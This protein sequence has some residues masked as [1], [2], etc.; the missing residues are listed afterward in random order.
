MVQALIDI[1]DRTNRILNIIKAKFDLQDKSQAI[2]AM[3]EQYEEALL[4]PSLR[5]A[6]IKR[7]QKIMKDKPIKIGTLA[8]F[9][10]R[11]RTQ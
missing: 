3:A 7:A 1:D 6:Y 9:R 8:D 2:E 10:A 5:P 11:Y 4:E